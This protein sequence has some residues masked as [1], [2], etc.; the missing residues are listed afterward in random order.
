MRTLLL[1]GVLLLLCVAAGPA[2]A[3]ERA[4]WVWEDAAT[5]MVHD[6]AYAGDAIA[7]LQARGI[8]TV[9]LY[10]EPYPASNPLSNQP[11][12]YRALLARLRA[13][14][15]RAQ[16]LLG[17]GHLN[18]DAYSAAQRR[19]IAEAQFQRVLDYNATA[20]PAE[21]F[22]GI[23]LDI[24]PHLLAAWSTRRTTLL[25]QYL[26]LGRS[27]MALKAAS[28]QALQVG[29]AIPFWY[30]TLRLKWNRRTQYMH[31]HVLDV[32]DHVSLMDY[33]DRADGSDGIIAHARAEMD[34]AGLR[35]KRVVIGLETAPNEIPKVTFNDDSEAAFEQ[36]LSLTEAAYAGHRAFGGFAIHHFDAYVEWLAAQ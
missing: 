22:D 23:S 4:A 12:L 24:E 5:A 10:V 14:G 11:G 28:G 2:R 17:S 29:P 9:Y 25:Q 31:E 34:A 13:S 15:I 20:L 7:F 8:G 3:A 27:L 32:Y 1:A 33:R 18:S 19:A 35:G 30:D 16:A 21:R 6:P 36:A 26:D